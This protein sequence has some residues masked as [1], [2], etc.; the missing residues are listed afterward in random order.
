[1][2]RNS[3]RAQVA[4]IYPRPLYLQFPRMVEFK[5][6]SPLLQWNSPI[7]FDPLL[8]HHNAFG[9]ARSVAP[10]VGRPEV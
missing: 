10:Y 3:L 6:K 2:R 5:I 7:R 8:L 9:S 1:M 4:E